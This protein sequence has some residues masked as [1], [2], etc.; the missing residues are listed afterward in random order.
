MRGF[1]TDQQVN[2]IRHAPDSERKAP[3]SMHCS[4]EVFMET[5][6]PFG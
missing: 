6:F 2:M 3:Q 4:A 5:I 1:Q